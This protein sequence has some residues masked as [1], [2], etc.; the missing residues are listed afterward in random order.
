MNET[1]PELPELPAD[2]AGEHEPTDSARPAFEAEAEGRSTTHAP[3]DQSAQP[4]L[5]GVSEKKPRRRGRIAAVAAC[6]LLLATTIGAVGYTARTVDA[7]DRDP[8]APLWK[9]PKV[10]AEQKKAPERTGLAAMLVPYDDDAWTRGPDIGEFGSDA[11]LSGAQATDLRKESLRDLP[12][13]QRRQLERQID[14][15]DI[16]GMAMRSYL[17]QAESQSSEDQ[18]TAGVELVQMNK[19]A[20]KDIAT[21]QKDFLEILDVFRKGPKI[22]GH[23]NANCFLPPKDSD[24]KLDA[25]FCIAAQG[26]VLVT[27]DAYGVKPMDTKAVARLV[28]E[29]LDRISEPGEAV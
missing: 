15:Q 16:Q 2:T 14:R 29:Q 13:S 4:Q 1:S 8:G 12:R 28:R 20:V 17:G 19:G 11:V 21:F 23:K 3:A 7:A 6:V 22:E 10:T 5:P 25:V 24:V 18:F 9:F 27:V 26:D